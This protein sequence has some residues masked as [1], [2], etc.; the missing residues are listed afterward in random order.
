VPRL[1]GDHR[2]ERPPGRLPR[3]ERRDLDRQAA[4]AGETGHPRV[5]LDAEHRAAG[6]L[7]LPG[8]DAGAAPDVE[9][10]PART[11]GDDPCHQRAGVAGPGPVVPRGVDAERLGHPPGLVRAGRRR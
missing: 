1:G 4:L 3:L 2:V 11:A 9:H 6:R 10:V 7:E 8:G 5:G